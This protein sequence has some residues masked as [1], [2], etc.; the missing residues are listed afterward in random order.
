MEWSAIG[1]LVS[2]C[3]RYISHVAAI[4]DNLGTLRWPN[5]RFRGAKF[6]NISTT[7]WF[8]WQVSKQEFKTGPAC[9]TVTCACAVQRIWP[10]TQLKLTCPW[11]EFSQLENREVRDSVT[12]Q[13]WNHATIHYGVVDPWSSK[14]DNLNSHPLEVFVRR[15]RDPQLQMG[16]NYSYLF[17]SGPNI[18]KTWCL[19]THFIT[20][21]SDLIG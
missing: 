14:L 6:L 3:K 5:A 21:N 4:S 11:R 2:I 19:N 13:V 12:C 10:L 9:A 20:R 18:F 8:E 1:Q 15:Y 17:N 7:E 16:A